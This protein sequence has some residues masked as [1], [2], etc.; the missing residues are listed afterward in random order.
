MSSNPLEHDAARD[1]RIRER[2]YHLWKADG[3]PHGRDAEYWERASELVGMEES[4]GYGQISPQEDEARRVDGQI[5]EEASIQENL[6]EFPDRQTD[7][8][9]RVET[10]KLTKTPAVKPESTLKPVPRAKLGPKGKAEPKAKLAPKPKPE[11]KAKLAPNPKPKLPG[12]PE[13]APALV[14][15]LRRTTKKV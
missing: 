5:V 11:P 7:Q 15:V 3:E 2:A 8:G 13:A 10:P 9:D 14:R 4:A 12:K 1:A 6:G